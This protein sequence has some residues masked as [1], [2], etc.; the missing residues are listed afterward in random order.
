MVVF[1]YPKRIIVTPKFVSLLFNSA[2]KDWDPFPTD[3]VVAMLD[4]TRF[5]MGQMEPRKGSRPRVG[6]I[7]EL[8]ITIS[9][10]DFSR[11]AK[12]KRV[13]LLNRRPEI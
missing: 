7:T 11:I 12:A 10:Q 13:A 4:G 9:Y 2:T 3:A 1:D 8:R 6:D 5:D